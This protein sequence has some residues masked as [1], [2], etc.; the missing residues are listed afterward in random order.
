L[1]NEFIPI[2]RGA[3]ALPCSGVESFGHG[4]HG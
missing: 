3:W 4:F 2:A 1:G